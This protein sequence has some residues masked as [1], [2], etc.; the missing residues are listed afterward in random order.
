MEE[1]PLSLQAPHGCRRSSLSYWAEET[2]ACPSLSPT[3]LGLRG[4]SIIILLSYRKPRWR[5]LECS[6]HTCLVTCWALPS[7][8]PQALVSRFY[9]FVL[10]LKHFFSTRVDLWSVVFVTCL[11]T[12]HL[13]EQKPQRCR[14]VVFPLPQTGC[15]PPGVQHFSGVFAS[16]PGRHVW[17]QNNTDFKS[18]CWVYP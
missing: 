10:W 3:G 15:L 6:P 7:R 16:L 12:G 8:S 4:W 9:F 2:P 1:F 5:T 13:R 17:V 11:L 18:R 14:S